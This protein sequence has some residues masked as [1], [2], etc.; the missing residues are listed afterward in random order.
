[1]R[2]K[3]RAEIE[4]RLGWSLPWIKFPLLEATSTTKISF[5][6]ARLQFANAA[7]TLK[8]NLTKL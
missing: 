1:M 7:K 4:P 5:K 6:S 3:S 2:I 8:P